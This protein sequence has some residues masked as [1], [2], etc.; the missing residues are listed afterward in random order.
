MAI[1]EDGS[2]PPTATSGTGSTSATIATVSFSPPAGSQLVVIGGWGYTGA[3][4]TAPTLSASASAGGLTF[5]QKVF[6]QET[7][8]KFIVSAMFIADVLTAPG[9]ITVTMTRAGSTASAK[10]QLTVKVLTGA[11]LVAS[12]TGATVN[13]SQTST[14]TTTFNLTP[15]QL[16][17][18]VF[19][20]SLLA[21]GDATMTM[22]PTAATTSYATLSDTTSFV[23]IGHGKGTTLTSALSAT[24]YGWTNNAPTNVQTITQGLE[25]LAAAGGSPSVSAQKH[26]PGATARMR[27]SLW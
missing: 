16:G 5:T 13:T 25:I 2:A 23:T 24:S 9:A 21:D 10:G 1:A 14:K 11:A 15:T 20:Q 26:F 8:S 19:A 18:Q 4:S 12:Q 22:T 17:S 27:A 3:W 7:V 6:K